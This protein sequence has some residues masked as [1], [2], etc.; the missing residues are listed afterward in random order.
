MDKFSSACVILFLIGQAVTGQSQ[1]I[2]TVRIGKPVILNLEK[3]GFFITVCAPASKLKLLA[4][5]NLRKIFEQ[6]SIYL[7][8]GNFYNYVDPET[9]TINIDCLGAWQVGHFQQLKYRIPPNS[10]ALFYAI[11]TTI[12]LYNINENSLDHRYLKSRYL[13]RVGVTIVTPNCQE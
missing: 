8:S 10:S 7:I 4:T 11:K 1:I 12:D 9:K 5:N 13:D 2:N 6:D 3:R